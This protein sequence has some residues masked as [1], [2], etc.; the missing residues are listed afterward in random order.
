MADIVEISIDLN[1]ALNNTSNKKV[2]LKYKP[3][4]TEAEQELLRE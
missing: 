4:P 2:S 3:P 1:L